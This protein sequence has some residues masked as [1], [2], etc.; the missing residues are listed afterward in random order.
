MTFG[1]AHFKLT[2][3]YTI[4]IPVFRGDNSKYL[5]K[6][7]I[8]EPVK[9]V[10]VYFILFSTLNCMYIVKVLTHGKYYST[11]HSSN[12]SNTFQIILCLYN[13][14]F[15]AVKLW[16]LFESY[17]DIRTMCTSNDSS[18]QLIVTGCQ[19]PVRP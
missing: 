9:K 6:Y 18:I 14:L 2:L 4:L 10:L 15:E 1:K 5:S 11:N 12:H 19:D 8:N 3:L 17:F 7:D 13:P 16:F